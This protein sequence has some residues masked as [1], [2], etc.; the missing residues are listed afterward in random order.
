MK[1][2]LIIG[3]SLVVLGIMFIVGGYLLAGRK[4]SGFNPKNNSY[5][6]K[7]YECSGS[8][9]NI[10]VN[11]R[12]DHLTVESGDVDKVTVRY[13]DRTDKELYN[14]KEDD[15]T[16]IVERNDEKDLHFFELNGTD[17]STVITVPREYKGGIELHTSSGGMEIINIT[18][19]DLTAE[20]SSGSIKLEN[21]TADSA[22]VHNTS[23]SIKLEN[24]T[25]GSDISVENTS[26]S[27]TFTNVTADGDLNAKGSSGS[28][29]LESIKASGSINLKNTSGSI[30]G[31][32]IGN[33]DDYKIKADVTSGSCNLVDS[34]TGSRELNVETTSGSI[35]ID[36]EN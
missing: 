28:I 15:T 24:I 9:E 30:K 21:V 11:E 7:T 23:G 35:N 36:F 17:K 1:N 29:K 34:D 2:V 4:L 22:K 19:A 25:S 16:L 27:I 26:G 10:K 5:A 13:Y 14:I 12:S 20:N 18:A 8:I 3:A 31:T 6:E 32:I 33:E